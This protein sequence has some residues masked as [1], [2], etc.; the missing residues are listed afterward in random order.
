MSFL[1]WVLASPVI[2]P[3]TLITLVV[4]VVLLMLE[5][6]ELRGRP[7]AAPHSAPVVALDGAAQIET[8]F[9]ALNMKETEIP[10]ERVGSGGALASLGNDL[11]VMTHEG[12]F[13][14]AG[15]AEAKQL[16]I[17]PPPNGWS[18]MLAFAE[19]NPDY[20]FAHFFFR[21]NDVDV[22][23][24]QL[25][26]SFTE[27]VEGENCYRT[28]I[29]TAPLQGASAETA[30]IKAEDWTVLFGTEPC[31]A[32]NPEGRA[33]QGHM[34]GGRFRVD[35]N[36]TLFLAAGDYAQDGIYAP[37]PLSQIPDQMY[38]KVIAV[39][40]ATGDSR[41]VS[42]GHS[43]MQGIALDQDGKLWTVEHGRR[44]GDELNLIREGE[45]YGWPQVSLG[46]RYNKLPLPDTLDYGRHPDF[47]LPAY[48]W[49]PSVA[50]SSLMNVDDFHPAWDGDLIA[51]SLAG[52]SLFR[53]RTNGESILF[54]ERIPL[55]LRI[56]YVHQHGDEL[57][58]WTDQRKV[59]RLT[60]GEFDPSFQFAVSKITDLELPERKASAVETAL[61]G[62]AECH[63]FGVLPST[64]APSLGEVFG[65]QIAGLTDF[66]YSQS[67]SEV[68]GKWT[69]DQLVAFLD[70][71]QSIAAETSMP[72]PALDDPEVVN[73]I[74]D[75]LVSLREQAE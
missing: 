10:V 32:P 41:V 45:D 43:N 60:V 62:C 7:V 72:D 23:D 54:A 17:A 61:D 16:Q 56:R 9:T 36:G 22:V 39:D 6:H 46:T 19:A 58:L 51:G 67:L 59:V 29:S 18:A 53:I 15:G 75:I 3:V 30:S 26:V 21:Y 31:L 64:S 68:G 74:V 52:N 34:A 66:D 35:A 55:G 33:I 13:F 14:E 40:L 57:A 11:I 37:V 1:K 24:D 2:V 25:I 20:E 12:G 69:R 49:L 27:W 73:A 38:G 70:N 44:G 4:S 8:I 71:P 47:Q 63:G 5:V 65:R 28:A 48:S 42:Q 50:V